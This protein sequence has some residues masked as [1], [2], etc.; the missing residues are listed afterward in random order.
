MATLTNDVKTFIVQALACFDAPSQVCQAVKSVYGIE[1]TRQQVETHDPTKTSGK[2]LAKR[3]VTLFHDT[4]EQFR[5]EMAQIPVA[6]RAFRLRAM[7][8]LLEKAEKAG[9]TVLCAKL[10]EQAA[11][12]VGD[13]YQ[14]KP[15]PNPGHALSVEVV[16]P[17]AD[18]TLSV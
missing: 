8:R 13:H 14:G 9:N 15:R 7:Q 3:W 6:N 12:E 16:V 10:L 2:G 11:R 1:V 4:R 5:S 17:P 18:Y